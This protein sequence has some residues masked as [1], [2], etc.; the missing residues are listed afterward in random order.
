[1]AL[2]P[3]HPPPRM[4]S[5]FTVPN[6]IAEKIALFCRSESIFFVNKQFNSL[7]NG[8]MQTLFPNMYPRLYGLLHPQWK[9]VSDKLEVVSRQFSRAT[10]ICNSAECLYIWNDTWSECYSYCPDKNAR[11]LIE[12][13]NPPVCLNMQYSFFCDCETLIAYMLCFG[14][15]GNCVLTSVKFSISDKT[16]LGRTIYPIQGIS[17]YMLSADTIVVDTNI[18]SFPAMQLTGTMEHRPDMV[19]H[20]YKKTYLS[21]GGNLILYEDGV[22]RTLG[23]CVSGFRMHVLGGDIIVVVQGYNGLFLFTAA[24]GRFL[25][26]IKH[27]FLWSHS[28]GDTIFSRCTHGRITIEQFFTRREPWRFKMVERVSKKRIKT[29]KSV[30]SENDSDITGPHVLHLE[31]TANGLLAR[32]LDREWRL[33]CQRLLFVRRLTA[34]PTTRELVLTLNPYRTVKFTSS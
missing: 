21:S 14:D 18:Y 27:A 6:D 28:C 2:V 29:W 32:F 7:R 16:C 4:R 3:A 23:P 24:D 20:W 9:S 25:T 19:A 8:I 17:V 34:R 1:M 13:K 30:E 33:N 31:N 15:D 12:W 10:Y 11:C 22:F 5:T 26:R